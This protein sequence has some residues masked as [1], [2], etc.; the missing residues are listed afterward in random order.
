MNTITVTP[1]ETLEEPPGAVR[2]LAT[3]A[4]HQLHRPSAAATSMLPYDLVVT[5]Q[6]LSGH[7]S[8]QLKA[9][10][11]LHN[12]PAV[13]A[14]CDGPIPPGDGLEASIVSSP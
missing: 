4:A 8:E 13:T 10:I 11:Q 3:E 12:R 2:D 14:H 1:A 9:A 6:W 7:N 5:E